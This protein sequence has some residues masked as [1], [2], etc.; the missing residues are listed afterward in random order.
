MLS[1]SSEAPGLCCIQL[2]IQP[3]SIT[4]FVRDLWSSGVEC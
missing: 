4:S 3:V 2:L 1:L